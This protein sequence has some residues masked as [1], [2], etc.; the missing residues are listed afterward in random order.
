MEVQGREDRIEMFRKQW[1]NV[2]RGGGGGKADGS[3]GTKKGMMWKGITGPFGTRTMW[4]PWSALPRHN[5]RHSENGERFIKEKSTDR[6][7]WTRSANR[8]EI[9]TGLVERSYPFDESLI[10]Q[11]NSNESRPVS[12]YRCSLWHRHD[13]PL[14]LPHLQMNIPPE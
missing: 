11:S 14:P 5:G 12:S 4:D 1:R 2:E 9:R 6:G 10:S 13:S 8:H 7:G 3:K